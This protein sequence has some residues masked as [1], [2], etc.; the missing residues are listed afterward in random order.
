MATVVTVAKVAKVATV[1][2]AKVTTVAVAEVATVAVA[3]VTTVA[4]AE[5]TTVAVAEVTPVYKVVSS[6]LFLDHITFHCVLRG[7]CDLRRK[8]EGLY[9]L[10][11]VDLELKGLPRSL[12]YPFFLLWL[13]VITKNIWTHTPHQLRKT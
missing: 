3:E 12:V 5:V 8:H 6:I 10:S 13:V 11:R 4:V 1:V 9:Q 2:V 7:P